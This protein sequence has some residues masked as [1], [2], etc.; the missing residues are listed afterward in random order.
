MAVFDVVFLFRFVYSVEKTDPPSLKKKLDKELGSSLHSSQISFPSGAQ[1]KVS[2]N[3]GRLLDVTVFAPEDDFP[4]RTEGI[5]GNFNGDKT[6]DLMYQGSGKVDPK[7]DS[8]YQNDPFVDSWR[9][10]FAFVLLM[11]FVVIVASRPAGWPQLFKVVHQ[12]GM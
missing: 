12:K 10:V 5:C 8:R 9:F 1:V 3:G 6:D 7:P 2:N 11:I 4:G